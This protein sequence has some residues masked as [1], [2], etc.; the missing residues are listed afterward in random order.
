MAQANASH[1]IFQLGFGLLLGHILE[2]FYK[3][4]ALDPIGERF[5]HKF[6]L[7]CRGTILAMVKIVHIL[8]DVALTLLGLQAMSSIVEPR[9]IGSLRPVVFV[10]EVH[11][12]TI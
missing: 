7:G 12:C 11:T 2:I 8:M 1:E 4:L 5:F 6:S 10:A 9:L 3:V